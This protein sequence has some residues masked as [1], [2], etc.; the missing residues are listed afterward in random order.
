MKNFLD[1]IY[2]IGCE[3]SIEGRAACAVLDL[4]DGGSLSKDDLVNIERI[5]HDNEQFLRDCAPT[6]G[7]K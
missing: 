1:F 2:E 6:G 4:I 5:Y 3:D 7:A